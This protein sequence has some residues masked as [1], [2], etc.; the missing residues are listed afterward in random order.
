MQGVSNFMRR[1]YNKVLK[2]YEGRTSSSTM[3]GL[4]QLPQLEQLEQLDVKEPVKQPSM[5][6]QM[7]QYYVAN[8]KDG[9]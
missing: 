4:L 2:I 6:W 9:K 8:M 1:E 7:Y 3:Y 5:M